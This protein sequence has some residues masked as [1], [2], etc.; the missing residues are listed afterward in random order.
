MLIG[1]VVLLITKFS[2]QHPLPEKKEILPPQLPYLSIQS[3]L[4]LLKKLL[5]RNI[6]EEKGGQLSS[7]LSKESVVDEQALELTDDKWQLLAVFQ[8]DGVQSVAVKHQDGVTDYMMNDLLPDGSKITKI[9]SAG[10][11]I[12]NKGNTRNVFLFGKQ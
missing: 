5:A 4:G 7:N 10:M 9:T 1:T 3:D 2:M 12:L 11:Q 8:R 6:W